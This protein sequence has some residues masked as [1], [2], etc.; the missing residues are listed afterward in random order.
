MSGFFVFVIF[1]A[2]ILIGG[3]LQG[4]ERGQFNS[5]QEIIQPSGTPLEPSRSQTS[6]HDAGEYRHI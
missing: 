6:S 4:K 5:A 1:L 2:L 3:L